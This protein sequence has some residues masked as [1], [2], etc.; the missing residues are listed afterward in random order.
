MAG[1]NE[2]VDVIRSKEF[3]DAC[4]SL[5]FNHNQVAGIVG[6]VTKICLRDPLLVIGDAVGTRTVAVGGPMLRMPPCLVQITQVNT[7]SGPSITIR[8]IRRR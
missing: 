2:P 1:W 6:A 7:R 5:G 3:L 4:A 8:H